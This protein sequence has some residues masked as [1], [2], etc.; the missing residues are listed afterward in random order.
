[1]PYQ[2]M[3]SSQAVQPMSL[4]DLEQIL[5]DAREG[6]TRRGI[7][8]VLI[9]A[10]GVFVQI[11]EG[12]EGVV[13]AVMARIA[14]D[15]RHGRVKVFQERESGVRAFG[16]WSMAYLAPEPADLAAWV[17]L[18]GTA[19]IERVLEHVHQDADRMPR[20]MLSIV[21]ALAESPHAQG[22]G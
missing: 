8:G 19:S 13:R 15:E 16:E 5:V 9:Y 11:L 4:A 3:Y 22:A 12:D 20:V 7:T 2:I 10:D 14:R 18:E 21:E 1:M 6:N 17:G